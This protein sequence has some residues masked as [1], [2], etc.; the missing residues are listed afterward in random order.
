MWTR[1]DA[2]RP[3]FD[4]D[5]LVDL[6]AEHVLA[7]HDVVATRLRDMYG[8]G[9]AQDGRVVADLE[10]QTWT[11]LASLVERYETPPI[12]VELH[13]VDGTYNCMSLAAGHGWHGPVV[14]LNRGG[15]MHAYRLE[16]VDS[17][18]DGW[19]RAARWGCDEV[20]DEVAQRPASSLASSR[21]PR[22]A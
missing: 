10:W 11:I 13:P 21:S 12:V 19:R 22:T 20:A 16:G 6:P 14:D 5:A 8:L 9:A 4:E 3:A 1:W 2:I 15:G 18:R 7:V 17:V